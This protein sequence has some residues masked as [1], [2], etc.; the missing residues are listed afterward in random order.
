M[1]VSSRPELSKRLLSEEA[2]GTSNVDIM[3]YAQE[4]GVPNKKPV[5][6]VLYGHY[7]PIRVNQEV[8]KTPI[9]VGRL[10]ARNRPTSKRP[11]L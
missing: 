2:I 8:N 7:T 1:S 11:E 10:L 4:N 5:V 3:T 9:A 6:C